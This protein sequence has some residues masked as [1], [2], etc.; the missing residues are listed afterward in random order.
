MFRNSHQAQAF[1]RRPL[2]G[3]TYISKEAKKALHD[4]KHPLNPRYFTY[5]E[6]GRQLINLAIGAFLMLPF[7]EDGLN[8]AK[9]KK[10]NKLS[11]QNLKKISLNDVVG[12]DDYKFEVEQVVDFFKNSTKYKQIGADVTKGVLLYGKPGVGKTMLA[13][14]LA[15]ES[16]FNFMYTSGSEFA[17]KYFGG[18]SKKVHEIFTEAEKK[19]PC[20]IFIDEIDSIGSKRSDDS[21][22]QVGSN[23]GLNQLLHEMDGFKKHE[24]IIVIGAT[25]RFDSLDPALLRPG[26][27][28]TLIEIPSLNS[29]GRMKL[30]DLYL[31]KVNMDLMSIDKK[32]LADKTQG[33]TGADIKNVFNL[34][35][36]NAGYTNKAKVEDFDL[37]QAVDRILN[38]NKIDHSE[39]SA[40]ETARQAYAEAAMAVVAK[41]IGEFDR[42]NNLS[43]N[44]NIIKSGNLGLKGK[45]SNQIF[46]KDALWNNMQL[47]VSCRAAE[48]LIY[49]NS[50]LSFNCTDRMKKA[51]NLAKIY[52]NGM[53][54]EGGDDLP[55]L[56]PDKE[57]S[58]QMLSQQEQQISST[59]NACVANVKA[60]LA[61][62]MENLKQL[63][64]ELIQ[65]KVL[66]KEIAEMYL[67]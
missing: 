60:I 1:L 24:N 29:Q 6:W 4:A 5:L 35:A 56:I 14:A 13:K 52:V 3:G 57:K 28:D 40:D 43:L 23:D 31:K 49:G 41:E 54:N 7:I 19:K 65:K 11:Q 17:D 15:S 10:A 21:T 39:S 9:K 63:G 42:I 2:Q 16:S 50:Q 20:V 27:F 66:S 51:R 47:F 61:K 64:N 25:N 55:L 34:A 48:E 58:T 37:D 26:R 32:K 45:D 38:G 62:K 36:I 67:K 46:S 8:E 22:L 44:K 33:F 59:I 30:F 53:S 12:I 18:T